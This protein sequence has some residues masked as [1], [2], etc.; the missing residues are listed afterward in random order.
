MTGRAPIAAALALA[1]ALA[2]GGCGGE[3]DS[4]VD[5]VAGVT[6]GKPAYGDTFIE[7]MTGNI[8]G[9]IPNVLS[10]SASFDVGSLI[11]SG[12]VM[13]DRE[14]NLI[15]ELAESWT[16]SKDC[17]D[18]TFNLRRNVRWHDERPFTAAD[19]VFTYETMINPK[20]PTAYREDFKAV[21]SVTA[22]DPYTLRVR[23]KQPYAKALQSWGIWMLPRHLLEPWVRE[24]KLREAPQNRAN[25]V[26]TGAYRFGEWRSG[27]KVVLL[28]NPDYFEG[29]PY[30]SRVVYRVIPS[31]ATIFLELKAKGV[32]S[33]GLTALQWKR[34]TDYPAFRRAFHRFQYPANAYTYLGFNH[35]DRR[36][37]DRRVRQAFAHA[38]NK[39]E[40]ID[41]V[42]LGLG[43][44]ATGPY[45]PG[46]W[47]YN[48]AVRTYPYDLE[49]ARALLAAAGWTEKNAEGLLVKDGQPFAFELMTNQGNDER[50]KVAEIVQASLKELGVR[51]DIRVIEWASFL[52]EYI[53]KRRFEA[54]I[55]G[56]GIGQDPDQYEIWH[57]S[58]TG[59]DELNHISYANPEVDR[60]LEQGRMSCVQAERTRYYHRLQ[61]V[62]AEDQPI[63]FLYFRDALPVV[64]SRVKG[65][66][67]SPNGIRYNFHEWFVPK[68]L[69]RYTAG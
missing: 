39:R 16:F 17:L 9:L 8:S 28:A 40:L 12:L 60:L 45:K 5:A 1:L 53:K 61:E 13:R 10:D 44:E 56:W 57:S 26:G 49:K 21:E 18:L 54:I 66:V 3:A 46:T 33:A 63:V 32:D 23:Y 6:G 34:Q 31:Q 50:K 67:P 14:L 62:L 35:K 64:S 68:H 55:L 11:Y 59:P 41:G 48:P 4:A 43:R 24:G 38:V 2:L 65:I 36:F 42:L 25:P 29:R 22:L 52:K 27:E 30:L 58:K 7:A 20:T 51:V 69:Q 37:A 19:V 15:G 47:A